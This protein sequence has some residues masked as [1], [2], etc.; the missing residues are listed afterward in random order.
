MS[1][2][3]ISIC[4]SVIGAAETCAFLSDRLLGDP[5]W[6]RGCHRVAIGTTVCLVALVLRAI[7]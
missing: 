7:V 4:L 3:L 6:V 1:P 5:T 2:L